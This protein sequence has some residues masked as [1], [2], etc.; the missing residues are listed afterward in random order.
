MDRKIL[1]LD[2]DAFYASVE[3]VDR[4]EFRGRPVIVGGPVARGVVSACSYEARVFGVHSAMPM[5]RAQRLCP[6]AIV[7]P[8]RMARYRQVSA[9]IFDIFGRYTDQVEPLSIDEAFLDVTGSEKLFGPAGVIAEKIR[10]DVC[11]E[12]GLTISAGVAPNKFLAKLASEACKPDGLLEITPGEVDAFLLPLPLSRLWGVGRVTA[13]RLA[14]QGL[15][16]V[17]DLREIPL[18]RLQR[19]FGA[20]GGLLYQLARGED[21]R[22]VSDV[23]EVK[24]IGHEDT[25]PRDLWELRTLQLELLDLA[26]RVAARLRRKGL[27][28]RGLTLKVRYADF[29]TVTRSRTLSQGTAHAAEISRIAVALLEKTEAGRKGVR[30]MGISMTMLQPAERPQG[31]LFQEGRRRLDDLDRAVDDLRERFGGKGIRR[32]SLLEKE[33]EAPLAVDKGSDSG[34]GT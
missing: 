5:A 26:E 7:L 30:L 3:Q 8:V 21:N 15:H 14:Q 34:E 22:P 32:G 17:R 28:A 4:P 19:W 29:S 13:Q 1:H 18:E 23:T 11:R 16:T 20:T 2:M 9:A 25:F 10:A 6:E 27:V 33:P 12:T 31:E 24:S